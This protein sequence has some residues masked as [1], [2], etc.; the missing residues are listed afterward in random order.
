MTIIRELHQKYDL[1]DPGYPTEVPV[2]IAAARM[3]LIAEE[4][5]EVRTDF[6][7]LLWLLR[8]GANIEKILDQ[9]RLLLK[10]LADLRCQIDGAAVTFGLDIEGA[11]RE[12]HR[13]NMTKDFPAVPGGKLVKGESYEEADMHQ[14]VPAVIEGTCRDVA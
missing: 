3:R 7:K 10:E 9:Y 12:V 1:G 4:Y 13:S 14:F 11:F 2:E 5:E 6:A 8:G